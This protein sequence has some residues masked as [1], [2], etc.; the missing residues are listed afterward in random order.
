[1]KIT[2]ST[3][4]NF[5]KAE[6]KFLGS[7]ESREILLEKYGLKQRSRIDSIFYYYQIVDKNKYLLFLL[8]YS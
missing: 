2:S 1:M 3:Y 4:Q 5:R 7:H 8:T 6:G